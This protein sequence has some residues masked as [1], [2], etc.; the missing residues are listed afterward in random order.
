[1]IIWCITSTPKIL[2]ASINRLVIVKSSSEGPRLPEGWLWANTTEAALCIM[3]SL[4]TSRGCTKLALRV[5]IDTV[6]IPMS[7]FRG[8]RGVEKDKFEMLLRLIFNP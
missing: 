4:N 8:L 2:P 7:L 5:P 1:M 6:E 3:A